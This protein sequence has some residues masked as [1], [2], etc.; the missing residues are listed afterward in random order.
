MPTFSTTTVND[1]TTAAIL[2]MGS[3]Q[4]YFSYT[5]CI[6]CG[7]PSVTLLDERKD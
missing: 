2:M 1:R 3:M 4:K 5:C 6:E 7:I